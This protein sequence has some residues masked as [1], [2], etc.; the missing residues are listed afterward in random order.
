MQDTRPKPFVFVLMP[1]AENFNDIYKLGIKPACILSGAYCERVDEQIFQE[2][3]LDRVYNQIAKADLIISEMTGRNPNVFYE[4]GSAHALGKRVILLTQKPDDIPFDLQHYPHIIYEGK[5]TLLKEELERRVSWYVNQ[6]TEAVF[7]PLSQLK[8]FT[9]GQEITSGAEVEI[10][11]SDYVISDEHWNIFFNVSVNNTGSRIVDASDITISLILPAFS[12]IP[13]NSF[14]TTDLLRLPDGRMMAGRDSLK[15][16]FPQEWYSTTIMNIQFPGHVLD[17][18]Q[19]LDIV[20]RMFTPSGVF[21]IPFKL[22]L[23]PKERSKLK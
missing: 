1:F 12:Q 9:N 17:D 21:D 11:R 7:D 18:L 22:K 16:L 3:I 6:P 2:S 20:L 5:I 15:K 19:S 23:V 10:P 13:E 14:S 8:I 4:T